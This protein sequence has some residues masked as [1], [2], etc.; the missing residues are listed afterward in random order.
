[1][2]LPLMGRVKKCQ[3]HF[4]MW[5]PRRILLIN[6]GLMGYVFGSLVLIILMMLLYQINYWQTYKKYYARSEILADFYYQ[7]S[8]IL[9]FSVMPFH[10]VLYACSINM[11]YTNYPHSKLI[12]YNI[13]RHITSQPSF[14]N[15]PII[16]Q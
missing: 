4:A 1:M 3:S 16:V 9:T 6:W 2:D 8:M 11:H 15:L 13:M 14:I 12:C 5:L 7:I 10:L